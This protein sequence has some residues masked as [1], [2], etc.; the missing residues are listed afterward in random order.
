MGSFA[1]PGGEPHGLRGRWAKTPGCWG[2]GNQL[3]GCTGGDA[4][5]PGGKTNPPGAKTT[6]PGA[7]RCPEPSPLFQGRPPTEQE[8][9]QEAPVMDPSRRPACYEPELGGNW[10]AGEG[11]GG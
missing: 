2:E 4:A 3:R 1:L 10:E 5:Q 8:P 7:E 11:V 9:G 6:P